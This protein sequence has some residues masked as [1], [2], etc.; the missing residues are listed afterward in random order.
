MSTEYFTGQQLN[1]H[2]SQQHMELSPKQI[3]SQGTKQA[4]KKKEITARIPSDHNPLKIELNN[5]ITSENTQII[6]G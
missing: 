5:K 4:H 6:G 3:I 2:S 1:T